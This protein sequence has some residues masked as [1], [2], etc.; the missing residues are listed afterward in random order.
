MRGSSRTAHSK[1]GQRSP[2]QRCPPAVTGPW[3]PRGPPPPRLCPGR[4]LTPVPT[5]DRYTHDTNAFS[6][7][8]FKCALGQMRSC[9]ERPPAGAAFLRRRR[10]PGAGRAGQPPA[11]HLLIPGCWSAWQPPVE[12]SAPGARP[13]RG[14]ERRHGEKRAARH[15]L[16]PFLTRLTLWQ[17]CRIRKGKPR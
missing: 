7:F 14:H 4:G 12:R 17:N 16:P 13:A 5:H 11:A 15:C 1:D 8:S 9:P 6:F 2:W 3:E 10:P